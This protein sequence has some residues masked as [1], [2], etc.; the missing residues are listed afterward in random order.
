MA[1][2]GEVTVNQTTLA[3]MFPISYSTILT[4][5]SARTPQPTTPLAPEKVRGL[6]LH[7]FSLNYTGFLKI[8][9][10]NTELLFLSRA[11]SAPTQ[12][13]PGGIGIIGGEN[14]LIDITFTDVTIDDVATPLVIQGLNLTG[15]IRITGP[16]TS[17]GIVYI[18]YNT[19]AGSLIFDSSVTIASLEL[20][21]CVVDRD[22]ILPSGASLVSILIYGQY[23]QISLSQLSNTKS[24]PSLTS[25][26]YLNSIDGKSP[27]DVPAGARG[28]GAY[29]LSGLT[30]AAY[31]LIN[32][33]AIP[34]PWTDVDIETLFPNLL[35]LI[36]LN[37]PKSGA[38]TI[39]ST[40]RSRYS[41]LTFI[42]AEQLT[43]L[44]L[45]ERAGSLNAGL[46]IVGCPLLTGVLLRTDPLT[47]EPLR[48]Y[49]T[50][51]IERCALLYLRGTRGMNRLPTTLRLGDHTLPDLSLSSK[52]LGAAGSSTRLLDYVLRS[53][54]TVG[55]GSAY[56]STTTDYLPNV[57]VALAELVPI[58]IA[59]PVMQTVEYRFAKP[60][61]VIATDSSG[62]LTTS[63]TQYSGGS[64]PIVPSN[65]SSLVAAVITISPFG[66]R[67]TIRVT[68]NG[69]TTALGST[70]S[71]LP[72]T[73][74]ISGS[75]KGSLFQSSKNVRIA[76]IVLAALAGIIA[77]S[78][79]LAIWVLTKRNRQVR[80]KAVEKTQIETRS[81]PI[82]KP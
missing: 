8:A 7:P 24:Y 75:T 25:L 79:I 48:E 32:V 65:G 29:T 11:V 36:V 81:K 49:R 45:S 27:R 2:F 10:L 54:P 40:P 28:F 46:R 69:G 58:L 38:V 64:N 1:E 47:S 21:Q 78:V 53:L 12:P 14:L 77:V 73:E 63:Y 6:I 20:Y 70:I 72:T 74:S 42:G 23:S 56:P 3:S 18:G 52:N 76:I 22:L 9:Q 13:V 15:D 19:I 5:M 61:A 17:F 31:P 34:D 39:P 68:Q 57:I 41:M 71:D 50:L 67:Y 26:L 66:T 51:I 82:H 43:S 37:Y 80:T 4:Y 16:I 35:S 62:T 59:Y 33:L 30:Q 60:A 44:N 55:E